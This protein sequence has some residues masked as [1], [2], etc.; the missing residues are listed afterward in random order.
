[1]N[2][3]LS[4]ILPLLLA[5]LA[6]G[7]SSPV[8]AAPLTAGG[9]LFPAPGEAGPT[10][11]ISLVGFQLSPFTTPTFEGTLASFALSGDTSNPYGGLTFIY[12]LA[13]SIDSSDA[14]GRLALNGFAGFLTDASY[15]AA[16][17]GVAP[18]FIDRDPTGD[19]IGATSTPNGIDPNA[20]FLVPNSKMR[21]LFIR[22][23]ATAWTTT[24]ASL[25]DGSVTTAAIVGPAVPEP[26]T[27]VLAGLGLVGLGVQMV[28]RRK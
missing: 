4:L 16:G 7:V 5:V 12:L 22:T 13:N 25:I 20:G 14:I 19:V 15:E 10:G 9:V 27:L 2:R 24:S 17:A 11:S 1:M 26:S 28:R 3:K 8:S 18:G 23:S 6:V 21:P